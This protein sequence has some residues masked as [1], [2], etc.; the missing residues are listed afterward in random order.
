MPKRVLLAI[1][2]RMMRDL[3][4][5][6]IAAQPDLEVIGEVYGEKDVIA[7]VEALAPDVVVIGLDESNQL[8]PIYTTFLA[9]RP[10]LKIVGV[11]AERDMSVLFW[12]DFEVRSQQIENSERGLL[13]AVRGRTNDLEF[14]A[15]PQSNKPN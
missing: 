7:G 14:I 2:T 4:A 3:V 1:H 9:K 11:A 8:P 5:T 6:L 10:D 13:E 12:A 15:T